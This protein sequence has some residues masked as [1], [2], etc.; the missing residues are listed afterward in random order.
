VLAPAAV[1]RGL[2]VDFLLVGKGTPAVD[3]PN[4]TTAGFVDDLFSVLNVADV[5]V[6]PISH[7]GGTKTKVYDYVT[8]GLPMVTTSKGIEGIDLVDGTHAAVVDAVD[9]AF[10]D[11]LAG[12]LDS[13]ARRDRMRDALSRLAGEW[14][15]ASSVERLDTFYRIRCR[16]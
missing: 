1:E 11:A 10:V 5:A 6:V 3:R 4:V 16:E 8:L 9:E 13:P 2:D 12:L 14:S 7:G 15:W